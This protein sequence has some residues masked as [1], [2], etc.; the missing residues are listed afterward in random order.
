[1]SNKSLGYFLSV[2]LKDASQDNERSKTGKQASSR[3]IYI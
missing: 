3:Y 2:L 1:M